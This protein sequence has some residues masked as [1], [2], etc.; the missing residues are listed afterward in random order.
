MRAPAFAGELAMALVEIGSVSSRAATAVL[1]TLRDA[2]IAAVALDQPSSTVEYAA[3][4]TSQVRIA[5]PAE[6]VQRARDVLA[7][8]AGEARERLRPLVG[9]MRVTF[10]VL[11]LILVGVTALALGF[12]VHR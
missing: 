8:E 10:V 2:G 1:Q 4:G 9:S 12:H 6:Q 11:I 5:V 3:H 7:A